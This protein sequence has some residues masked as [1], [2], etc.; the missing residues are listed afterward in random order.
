MTHADSNTQVPPPPALVRHNSRCR[1]FV[2]AL[3]RTE[4]LTF[5]KQKDNNSK[6][7]KTSLQSEELVPNS[8]KVST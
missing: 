3:D 2:P 1:E 5:E 8:I 4:L 6:L 7:C